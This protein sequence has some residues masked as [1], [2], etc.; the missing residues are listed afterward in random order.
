MAEENVYVNNDIDHDNST[1]NGNETNADDTSGDNGTNDAANTDQKEDLIRDDSH[2]ITLDYNNA[3]LLANSNSYFTFNC[4]NSNPDLL[5]YVAIIASSHCTG[6]ISSIEINPNTP[7]TSLVSDVVGDPYT[8]TV[9]RNFK[10]E[11][12]LANVNQGF[13]SLEYCIRCDIYHKD[14]PEF[15]IKAK[16]VR[17][18]ARC[19]L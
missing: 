7:R 8:A 3:T 1:K 13:D 10:D 17:S 4:S 5:V 18:F 9:T 15:S 6:D 11:L 2:K 19:C 14:H 16:K 12:N